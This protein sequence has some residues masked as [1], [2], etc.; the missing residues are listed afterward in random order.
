MTH[1]GINGYSRLV[2]YLKC[3]DNNQASTVFHC[4]L[5]ATRIYGIS[6]R[7]RCDQGRENIRVGQFMLEQRGRDRGSIIVASSVHNQRIKRL[8]RDMHR[9]ATQLFYRLFYFLEHCGLLDPVNENHLFALHHIFLP[10]INRSL[11]AFRDGWNQH[12]IRTERN[13]SPLQLYHAG[14]LRLQNSGLAA[15]D[16]FNMVDNEYGLDPE[17][18]YPITEH[19]E[20]YVYTLLLSLLLYG[21]VVYITRF[22]YPPIIIYVC[23]AGCCSSS[24]HCSSLW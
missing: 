17:A 8:W 3:S 16:L 13:H 12:R 20:A 2:V 15:M 11:D 24:Y 1:C 4:F 23:N 19:S 22:E 18:P 9:C 14:T 5:Q 10:R 7:V 6:S 21:S